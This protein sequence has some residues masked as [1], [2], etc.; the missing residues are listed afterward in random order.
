MMNREPCVRFHQARGLPEGQRPAVLCDAG[1]GQPAVAL[2][3]R[4]RILSNRSGPVSAG[5]AASLDGL[6]LVTSEPG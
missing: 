3:D 1:H 5:S 2:A 4:S 6:A